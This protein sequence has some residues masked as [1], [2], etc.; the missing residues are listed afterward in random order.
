MTIR[1]ITSGC[2][3]IL[4]PLHLIYLDKCSRACDYLVVAIDSD[5]LYYKRKGAMPVFNERDR[6]F[7]MEHLINIKEVH[8]IDSL[9]DLELLARRSQCTLMFKHKTR[10]DSIPV[11]QLEGIETVI[12]ADVNV[13]ETSTQIKNFLKQ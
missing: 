1:G 4:H 7:I 13:Y 10:M 3:D 2:F 9:E 12:I 11:L 6:K 5:E 8:I